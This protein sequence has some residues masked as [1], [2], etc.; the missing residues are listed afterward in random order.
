ML[1]VSGSV[2][3]ASTTDHAALAA[4][5]AEALRDVKGR[6]IRVSPDRVSFRGGVFR[7]FVTDWN[8][9]NPFGHGE[10]VV[11]AA[12]LE[13]RYELSVTQ[14]VL[15]ATAIVVIGAIALASGSAPLSMM[16]F[17]IL[18]G[19][20][21]VAGNLLIGLPRFRHFLRKAV[22]SAPVPGLPAPNRKR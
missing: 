15:F 4:H 12:R 10:L 11:D 7:F 19:A 1:T 5:L 6:D 16:P 17:F 14:I 21:V 3:F 20:I 2:E 9:L 8:V 22:N 13:V 18:A